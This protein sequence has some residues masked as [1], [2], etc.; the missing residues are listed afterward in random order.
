[1][2]R[3]IRQ[4]SCAPNGVA[5]RQD[6]G[7]S[8]FQIRLFSHQKI[9]LFFAADVLNSFL[10]ARTLAHTGQGLIESERLLIKLKSVNEAQDRLAA[11]ARD[12]CLFWAEEESLQEL[13]IGRYFHFMN[14]R[15][16]ENQK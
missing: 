7:V 8:R 1:M 10:Q 13:A 14:E 5:S 2:A 12:R 9:S 11:S 15:T 6:R 3:Q 16:E 4:K